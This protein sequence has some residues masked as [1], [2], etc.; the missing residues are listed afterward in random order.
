[1]TSAMQCII[2]AAAASEQGSYTAL[3]SLIK[4]IS[5]KETYSSGHLG[6]KVFLSLTILRRLSE[7][8]L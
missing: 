3:L 1:M 2:D 8:A 4:M 7:L 5:N 6:P